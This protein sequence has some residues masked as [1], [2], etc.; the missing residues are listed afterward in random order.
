MA[1]FKSISLG[2][3]EAESPW[4]RQWEWLGRLDTSEGTAL[5]AA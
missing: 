3:L 2:R 5:L 1:A 4:G